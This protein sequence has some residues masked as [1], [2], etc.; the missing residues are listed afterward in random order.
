VKIS[1][2]TGGCTGPN[3]AMN[4][5]WLLT[6]EGESWTWKKINMHNTEWAP[7]RIWCHQ[8]CKVSNLILLKCY[9][10]EYNWFIYC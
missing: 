9:S 10:I 6:M 7:T 8:A 1:K 2:S 4:D 3:A 5:A